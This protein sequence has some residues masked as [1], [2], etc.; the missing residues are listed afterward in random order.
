M[1]IKCPDGTVL[2]KVIKVERESEHALLKDIRG[3][4][5]KLVKLQGVQLKYVM[6][7][8]GRLNDLDSRVKSL[9]SKVKKQQ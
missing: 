4:L 6:D 7:I 2:P 3:E 8:E 1:D 5:Q 9:D